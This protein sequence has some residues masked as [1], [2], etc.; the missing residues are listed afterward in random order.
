MKPSVFMGVLNTNI[1]HERKLAMSD[2]NTQAVPAT[3]GQLKQIVRIIHDAVPDANWIEEQVLHLGLDQFGAKKLIESGDELQTVRKFLIEK[4]KNLSDPLL[5][6]N[7][8]VKSKYGYHSGYH[9]A[10]PIDE[11]IAILRQHDWGREVNWGLNEEQ[12]KLLSGP[13]PQGSEGYFAVVFDRTMVAYYEND[14]TVDQS[15]PVTRV[16]RALRKHKYDVIEK[17]NTG[18][19]RSSYYRRIRNSADKMRRLWQSQGCPN[20][21]L[22]IPA[23]LGLA[24]A[25]KSVLRA[26]EVMRGSEFPLDAYEVL[27]MVLTHDVRLQHYHDLWIHLPGGEYSPDA[28]TSFDS[29]MYVGFSDGVILFGHYTAD[30]PFSYFGSVSGYLVPE[31]NP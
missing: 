3:E 20:G 2:K 10:R 1:H 11:Q 7:Q 22:L 4:I 26:R 13:V 30:E 24:H 15:L 27:Q 21:I 17:Y 23:Q 28:F 12:K 9:M 16:I 6:S 25:G 19:L 5:Y 8:V 14:L 31:I 18:E 29:A